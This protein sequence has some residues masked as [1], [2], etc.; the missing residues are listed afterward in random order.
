MKE[1][2]AIEAL[3]LQVKKVK[4]KNAGRRKK[5][6]PLFMA[7]ITLKLGRGIDLFCAVGFFFTFLNLVITQVYGQKCP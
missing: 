1:S 4:K 2:S 5:T 7:S 6:I 3:R